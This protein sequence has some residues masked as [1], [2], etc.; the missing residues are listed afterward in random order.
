MYT[1]LLK[2][3][4]FQ[5]LSN[6]VIQIIETVNNDTKPKKLRASPLFTFKF[7]FTLILKLLFLAY[8]SYRYN[9]WNGI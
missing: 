2:G 8:L 6:L 4:V 9:I 5:T 3:A 1:D 7:Y